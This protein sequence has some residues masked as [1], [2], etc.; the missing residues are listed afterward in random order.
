MAK[1][2][3]EVA[4]AEQLAMISAMDAADRELAEKIH[5]LVQKNAP[6]L[7]AKTWY[8]MPAYQR[9]G[10]TVLFFQ[11]AGKFKTR[12]ATLGF[13]HE[14]SL[15]DGNMWATSFAL[16]KIDSKVEKE[17]IELIRRAAS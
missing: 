7:V 10:K 17:L 15:D 16:L 2:N 5:D 3:N 6:E 4:L 14:A 13:Q 8:G 11:A 12:Y 1:I 9:D